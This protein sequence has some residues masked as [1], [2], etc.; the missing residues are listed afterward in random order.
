MRRIQK[1]NKGH[2]KEAND[3]RDRVIAIVTHSFE[4]DYNK[5]IV[6]VVV[7]DVLVLLDLLGGAHGQLTDAFC[8]VCIPKEDDILLLLDGDDGL[9][10]SLVRP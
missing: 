8:L 4:C 9:G 5:P 1:S 2:T 6:P 3:N 10:R 7:Q